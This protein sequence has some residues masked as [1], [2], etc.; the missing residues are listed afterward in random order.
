MIPHSTAYRADN[1]APDR[2]RGHGRHALQH[3]AQMRECAAAVMLAPV[4]YPFVDFTEHLPHR[5]AHHPL[6]D[7]RHKKTGEIEQVQSEVFV[8]LPALVAPRL[9]EIRRGHR[10]HP[11]VFLQLADHAVEKKLKQPA[12]DRQ[13]FDQPQGFMGGKPAEKVFA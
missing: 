13:G 11:A 12:I 2:K 7:N 8:L 10:Q 9:I 3:R 1:F 5:H 4:L 6:T